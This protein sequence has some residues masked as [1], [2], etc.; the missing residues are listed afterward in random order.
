MKNKISKRLI[1]ALGYLAILLATFSIIT[2][3]SENGYDN[4]LVYITS[5][6]AL[7]FAF[8][9][10]ITQELLNKYTKQVF[11]FLFL[12]IFVVVVE[13]YSTQPSITPILLIISATISLLTF[14]AIEKDRKKQEEKAIKEED[15]EKP[16]IISKPSDFEIKEED[17]DIKESEDLK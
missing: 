15:D 13:L 6:I 11:G 9:V 10:S 16:F 2:L 7:V 3:G 1:E 5:S 4:T 14:N 17:F 8:I 12:I